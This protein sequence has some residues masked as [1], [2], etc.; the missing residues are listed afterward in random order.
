M[1]V[2]PTATG[3]D[4]RSER[5]ERSAEPPPGSSGTDKRNGASEASAVERGGAEPPLAPQFER[6]RELWGQGPSCNFLQMIDGSTN[7]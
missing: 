3:G 6:Q 1:V 2:S 4:K 5:S 7:Q